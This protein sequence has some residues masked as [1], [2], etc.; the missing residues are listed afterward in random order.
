MSDVGRLGRGGQ[1]RKARMRSCASS[2]SQRS[3]RAAMERCDVGG[4]V[5]AEGAAEGLGGGDGAGSGLEHRLGLAAD[6]VVETVGGT[7]LVDE[8]AAQGEVGTEGRAGEEHLPGH[9]R[10]HAAHDEGADGGGDQAEAGLGEGE[11]D[12]LGGDGDVGDGEKAEAAAVDV[13]LHPG[14][15]RLGQGVEGGEHRREPRGLGDLAGAVGGG[16]CPHPVEVA[17][18]AEGRAGGSEDHGADGGIARRGR[19]RPRSALQSSRHSWRDACRG[20]RG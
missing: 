8:A 14:D 20:G 3:A 17:A 19:Q 16:L 12:A 11:A 2:V 13:A 5:A 18:G 1:P 15:Q 7:G 10:T 4:L 9:A 6:A